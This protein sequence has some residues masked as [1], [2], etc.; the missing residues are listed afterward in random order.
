MKGPSAGMTLTHKAML[1][2]VMDILF[3]VMYQNF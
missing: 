3:A 2:L 1:V